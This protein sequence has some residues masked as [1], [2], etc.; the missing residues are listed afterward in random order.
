M[1]DND[2]QWLKAF[3]SFS[4]ISDE[5][6][7]AI[8]G[9][10]EV[11]TFKKGE[12]LIQPGEVCNFI[13]H[14]NKGLLRAFVIHDGEEA[15][16]HFYFAGDLTS[17]Y[18]S[19]LTRQPAIE[20]LQAIEAGELYQLSY[21]NTQK[22]YDQF[23]DFDRFG[24]KM[25]DALYIRQRERIESL[26]SKGPEERYIELINSRPDF[27]ER[28]SS[29]HIARYLGIKPQSLSRIRQRLRDKAISSLK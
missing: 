19:F 16:R 10:Q 25:S 7:E 17:E 11:R 15:N 9:Y 28:I 13:A 26:L 20:Y 23:P 29:L 2:A 22:L 6:A 24:R 21:S 4:P 27:F 5:L 12:N 18:T 3:K 1:L 14:V 8:E